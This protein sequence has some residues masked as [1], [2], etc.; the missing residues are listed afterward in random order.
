MRSSSSARRRGPFDENGVGGH[1]S[2]T[3]TPHD[4]AIVS[5]SKDDP[6]PFHVKRLGSLTGG[7]GR[8][9]AQT[10]ARG[11]AAVRGT[12]RR[13]GEERGGVGRGRALHDFATSVIRR[14]RSPFRGA[15][16]LPAARY[17][18]LGDPRDPV[19]CRLQRRPPRDAARET[20]YACDEMAG[21]V[22]AAAMVRP[23]RSVWTWKRAPVIKRMKDKALHALSPATIATGRRG[24]WPAAR[25]ARGQRHRLH[26]RAGRRIGAS[27]I[28]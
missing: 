15:R 22:T 23:S 1:F 25:G 27:R 3:L 12:A 2:R 26:P 17:P 5:V 11:G 16:K 19:A 28:P 6:D 21:F 4:C 13:F 24:A 9:P 8:K 7:A 14:P 20:L 18:E 10:R